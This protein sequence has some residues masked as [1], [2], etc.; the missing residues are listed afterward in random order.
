MLNDLSSRRTGQTQIRFLCVYIREAHASDVWPIDGPQVWEPQTTAQRVQTALE[1]Q[2][3][4]KLSWPI[5]VDC[6]EDLVAQRYPKALN[7]KPKTLNPKP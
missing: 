1:F 4:C 7:R 2:R 3:Q 5:A 6:I